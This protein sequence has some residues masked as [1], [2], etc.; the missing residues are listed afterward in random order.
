MRNAFNEDKYTT[1]M[2]EDKHECPSGTQFTFSYYRHLSTL[3]IRYGVG[4]HFLYSKDGL[5]EQDLIAMII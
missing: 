5:T 1:I 4:V 3:L 2:W